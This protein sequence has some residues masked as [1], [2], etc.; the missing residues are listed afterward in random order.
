MTQATKNNFQSL[1]AKETAQRLLSLDRI[2]VAIHARPDADAVGTG[3]ALVKALT[4]LGKKAA[5]LCPDRIPERL[6]FLIEGIPTV[7]SPELDF[8]VCVDV[9]SRAQL[10][11][12]SETDVILA[13][14]HH[15]SNTPFADNLTDGTASSAAEVLLG[16]IDELERITDVGLLADIAYPLYAA[17]SSDTGGFTYSNAGP[18]CHIAAARLIECGIDFADINHKLFNSKSASLL[19]AEG[20]IASNIKTELS[21]EIAY[22]TVTRADRDRLGLT[23]SDFDT[24]VDII[25]SLEGVKI[26]LYVRENDDGTIRASM[27]STAFN[28]AQVAEKFGGGG[29][30]RA[31]GCSP[32]ATSASEGATAIIDEI[33]TALM[34]KGE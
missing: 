21:G 2:A 25:R 31:A 3:A 19:R 13:I 1:S 7:D 4:A 9:A 11:R 34:G 26:A 20:H 6:T 28:V 27:R 32:T 17:M 30:V 29:H 10:G 33:K 14:D 16:V 18:K 12:L 5:L 8:T 23:V 15:A 22:A 24:A